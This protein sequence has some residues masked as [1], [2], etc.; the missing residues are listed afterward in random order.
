MKGLTFEV[1]SGKVVVSDPC[2]EL[3]LGERCLKVLEVKNGIWH[4]NKVISDEGG[5]GS[6]VARLN[7]K[8]GDI[9]HG[10]SGF[11]T[12]S[13][14]PGDIGVDSGQAGVFD[15][16]HYRDD[17]V[18]ETASMLG[19]PLCQEENAGDKWYNLCCDRTINDEFE[20][21]SV[22]PF[23]CVSSSGFGDGGYNV[24]VGKNA[25][26]EIVEIEIVF[27]GDDEEED[28]CCAYCGQTL[29]GYGECEDC[30]DDETDD[31]E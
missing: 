17:S 26:G 25:Q 3:S 31:E 23:G 21:G 16:S 24:Y 11:V 2:Y 27:I 1:V 18:V 14:L 7:V 13:L 20:G 19:K 9:K 29:N 15:F 10:S 6:R 8:H 5:W 30:E 28:E 22:I 4:M 12:R